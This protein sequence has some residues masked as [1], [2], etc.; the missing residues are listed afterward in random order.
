[1]GDSPRNQEFTQ[2]GL[3]LYY[4][5]NQTNMDNRFAFG[6]WIFLDLGGDRTGRWS[7][8][9]RVSGLYPQARRTQAHLEVPQSSWASFAIAE[10]WGF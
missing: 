8:L 5:L 4:G 9:Y 2:R 7:I 6:L 1:M 3:C 10:P